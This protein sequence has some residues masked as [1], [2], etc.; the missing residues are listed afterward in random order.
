MNSLAA[1]LPLSYFS[2]FSQK[3]YDSFIEK[4]GTNTL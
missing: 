1:A 2:E 3:F 4:T